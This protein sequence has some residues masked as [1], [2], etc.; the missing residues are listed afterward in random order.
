MSESKIDT[1]NNAINN[2]RTLGL[3]VPSSLIVEKEIEE[4]KLISS[5]ISKLKNDLEIYAKKQ[6]S[7]IKDKVVDIELI[8]NPEIESLRS[9][10]YIT[11]YEE[12]KKKRDAIHFYKEI[13]LYK[14][15]YFIRDSNEPTSYLDDSHYS[16]YISCCSFESYDDEYLILLSEH[17]SIFA[18]SKRLL[19]RQP[20]NR[21]IR[22][23]QLTNFR[24]HNALVCKDNDVIVLGDLL[25]DDTTIRKSLNEL[26][27]NRLRTSDFCGPVKFDVNI[28]YMHKSS[29]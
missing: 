17:N 18:I 10:R 26:F 13:V 4:T 3:D 27:G 9:I 15:G 21:L 11:D 29:K 16:S 20:Q 5:K 19:V 14:E 12:Y 25:Y 2:L 23:P 8:F 22:L 6:F 24:I 7:E 28:D 1:I